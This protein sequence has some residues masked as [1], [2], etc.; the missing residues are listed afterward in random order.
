MRCCVLRFI[1]EML[2]TLIFCAVLGIFS[3][4]KVVQVP[5]AV[6]CSFAQI[7]VPAL[8]QPLVEMTQNRAVL[9]GGSIHFSMVLVSMAQ[10]MGTMA[11]EKTMGQCDINPRACDAVRSS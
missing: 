3:Q 9:L 2:L 4:K 8:A 10:M 1:F 5:L 6:I 7:L 11:N